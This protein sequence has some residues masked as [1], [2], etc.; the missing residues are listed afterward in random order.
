M[1]L[2]KKLFTVSNLNRDT[3]EDINNDITVT[4]PDGIFS[5]KIDSIDLK[6]LYIDY[7]YELLGSSN[8]QLTI[9]YPAR[10]TP[11]NITIDLD[12]I[13][14]TIR[15]DDELV[16]IIADA[17]NTTL[18][19]NNVFQV[20]YDNVVFYRKDIYRDSSRLI[21]NFTIFTANN[22]AFN[23]DFSNKFSIG[24]LLG[25]G[26]DIYEDNFIF[27][28]GNIPSLGA[29]NS[30]RVINSAYNTFKT[31]DQ[32]VDTACKLM[33]YDSDNQ[34]IPNKIDARDTTI[35]LP[36]ANGYIYSIGQ[37]IKYLETSMNEYK[38]EFTPEADFKIS[39]DYTTYKFTIENTTGARFGIGFRFNNSIYNNYGSL[40]RELGFNKTE[41]LYVTSITSIQSAAIF[42]RVYNNDY[43]LICSDLIKNNFDEQLMVLGS[44]GSY[45]GYESLFTIPITEIENYSFTPIHKE[46]YRTRINASLFAKKYSESLKSSKKV[47]FYLKS[48]T[49]RHIKMNAQWSINIM[50]NYSN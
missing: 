41:Y 7:D 48:S 21:S 17:I 30:I 31:Y 18:G 27:K 38:D 44:S 26:N 37:F 20:Y 22:V 49:G 47:N 34:K 16:L 8:N 11:V 46:D 4:F 1:S 9:T 24:P 3:E 23:L 43:I 28:G 39:F 33:L 42:D 35:S 14:E 45:S 29:Y 2:N 36:I 10:G 12:S 6:H 5:G 13:N 19:L 32:Y 50:I 15:T 25:F 40:H